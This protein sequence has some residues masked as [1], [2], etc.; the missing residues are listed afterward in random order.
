M[1]RQLIEKYIFTPGDA[2]VGTVKFPGKCDETQLLII[3]NKTTQENI[4]AIGDPTRSGSIVYDPDDNST[5]FSELE[6]VSTVTLSVFVISQES[7]T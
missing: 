7:L 5:F 3:A 2:N 4:Y 1:A 6:G